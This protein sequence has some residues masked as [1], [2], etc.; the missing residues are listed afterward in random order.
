M[1]RNWVRSLMVL[2]CVMLAWLPVQAAVDPAL[3]LPVPGP[4]PL[5]PAP[6]IKQ[7]SKL[8]SVLDELARLGA[9]GEW[10]RATTFAS[11]RGLDVRGRQVQVV[12]EGPEGGTT[13]LVSLAQSMGLTVQTSYRNWVRVLAPVAALQE[14]ASLPAV[15]QVRLPYRPQP[16]VTVSQGVALTGANAWHA[17]GYTGSG[18]KVAVIDLGFQNW[19]SRIA[20]GELPANLVVRSFR[21]DGDIQASDVHGTACA[22]IVYDMAP[23]VRLYLLAITDELELG[24]AVDY[25]LAQGIQVVSCSVSWLESGPFDGTGPICDIVNRARQGGIFWAQAAGNG[26]DK[27]WEGAWADPDYNGTLDFVTRDDTQSFTVAANAVIDAH[28]TWDDPWS[29]SNNDYDLYLLDRDG[30]EVA[31]SENE[32]NGN[33]HPSEYIQYQVGGSGGTYHLQIRR[34]RGSGA[35]RFELYSFYQAMEYQT[36]ASSLFIP[37]DAAGAVA[38]GAVHWQTQALESFSSRGPTND[39][40]LKPEFSAPDGVVTVSYPGGFSGTSAAAP[41]LAGAAALVRGAYP[42]YA[43]AD[44]ASFLSQRAVD[45]GA[46]GP[47]YLYGYGRLALG[48]DPSYATPTPTATRTPVATPT[49]T[50]TRT[51]TPTSIHT[52]TPTRTLV[53][54]S[55]GAIGGSVILQGRDV[56]GGTVVDVDGRLTTTGDNGSFWMEAVAPGMH[57]VLATMAGYLYAVKTDVQVVADQAIILPPVT[58]SGGDANGNCTVDLFDLVVVAINYNSAPPSDPRADLNGNDEVDIFDLVLVCKNLDRVCPQA[59]EAQPAARAQ[60]GALAKLRVSPS[61]STIVPGEL[62][63]VTVALDDV[64]ALYGADV[65]LS[66]DPAVLQAVD[67]DPDQPGV[68]VWHGD[69]LDSRQGI[70]LRDSVDN[71]RGDV[72]Y[73]VSLTRP[74]PPVSGSGVLFRVILRA[75]G[76]GTVPLDVVRATLVGSDVERIPA[77]VTGGWIS[78]L[79]GGPLYLPITIKMHPYPQQ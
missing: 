1:A 44:T 19:L 27:H 30:H 75:Q 7:H 17:A 60:A 78:V 33:D 15:Q 57:N 68:Q 12:L 10:S 28:L 39:G 31:S 13:D 42:G 21:S 69:L 61:S 20:A 56:H 71:R 53:P 24:Q 74:A 40:R 4:S 62:V 5:T 16:M 3:S 58:L 8:V 36:P 22:E 64:Q 11:Q 70:V 55:G 72:H 48:V 50:R 51:P 38:A 26:G 18:V 47:D 14:V 52:P 2:S 76:G 65:R 63:T 59:W 67:A 23:G 54:G 25:A 43:V 77:A 37:A 34:F 41:H 49:L 73:A 6:S 45:L 32:Q 9:A 46:A 79:A 35:A 29:A 66:F